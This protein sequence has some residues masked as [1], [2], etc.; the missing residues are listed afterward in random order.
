M[1]LRETVL[2]NG[3][4]QRRCN[5]WVQRDRGLYTR[6]STLAT[7][8]ALKLSIKEQKYFICLARQYKHNVKT[9]KYNF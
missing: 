2:A 9:R 7:S 4:L 8:L 5:S 1:I 6:L 3:S